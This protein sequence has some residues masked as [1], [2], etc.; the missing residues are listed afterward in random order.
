VEVNAVIAADL[1]ES[2]EC[3]GAVR[4]AYGLPA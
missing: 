3:A 1:A 4:A 2:G